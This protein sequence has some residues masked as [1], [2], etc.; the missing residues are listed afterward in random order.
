MRKFLAPLVLATTLLSALPAAAHDELPIDGQVTA[1]TATAIKV[2]T[3][4]GQVATLDVDN[5]TRVEQGGKRVGLKD[6]KVGQTVKALG[7]GDS[8]TD[9]VAIDVTILAPAKGR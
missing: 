9:L 3:K 5:N 6:L 8:M 1:V 2:K 7:Y 4:D